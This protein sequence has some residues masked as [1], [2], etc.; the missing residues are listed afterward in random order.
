MLFCS[1]QVIHGLLD[2]TMQLLEVPYSEDKTSVHGYYLKAHEGIPYCSFH[3]L[4]DFLQSI[5]L[6]IFPRNVVSCIFRDF[7]LFCTPLQKLSLYIHRCNVWT[8]IIISYCVFIRSLIHSLTRSFSHALTH[9]L[10][11]FY[12]RWNF[13]PWSLCANYRQ[14][15]ADRNHGSPTSWSRQQLWIESAMRSAWTGHRGIPLKKKLLKCWQNFPNKRLII[16]A[17][18]NEFRSYHNSSFRENYTKGTRRQCTRNIKYVEVF[19]YV[20]HWYLCA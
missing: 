2:R 16:A 3:S 5:W 9:S 11:Y 4:K 8:S 13:L 12:F 18:A 17:I 20:P 14:R 7:V 6:A 15:K 1:F 19:K 10:T